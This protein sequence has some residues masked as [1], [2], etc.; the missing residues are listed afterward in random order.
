MDNSNLFDDSMSFKQYQI[1]FLDT[2]IYYISWNQIAEP[3]IGA[4]SVWDQ[5]RADW[6]DPHALVDDAV[7]V[8]QPASVCHANWSFTAHLLIQL[9]LNALLDLGVQVTH[10][11]HTL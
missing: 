10:T 11:M 3:G 9:L 7:Q 5:H 8:W 2:S 1:H 4:G 6:S